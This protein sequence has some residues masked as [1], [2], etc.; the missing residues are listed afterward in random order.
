MKKASVFRIAFILLWLHSSTIFAEWTRVKTGCGNYLCGMQG[1]FTMND[2]YLFAGMNDGVYRSP[3]EGSTWTA[4]N[5]GLPE[6]SNTNGWMNKGITAFA[7]GGAN[8]FVG[9][10]DLGVFRSIDNGDNWSKINTGLGNLTVY[11]LYVKEPYLFSATYNGIYR[12]SDLDTWAPINNGLTSRW[13]YNFAAI[14]SRLFVATDGGGVFRS[15]DDG[16]TWSRANKGITDIPYCFAVSDL[17]LFCASLGGG[18]FRSNDS[19]DNW[20]P[21]NNGLT[22]LWIWGMAA[23]DQAVFVGTGDGGVFLTTDDGESW[24]NVGLTKDEVRQICIKGSNLFAGAAKGSIFMRPLTEMIPET[25]I[26]I[27]TNEL[28][29]DYR[30]QQNYPNPFNPS[31]T[32]EF[33]CP[34]QSY[35]S[36][37]IFDLL[38][39]KVTTLVDEECAPGHHT[40]V[41]SS[42]DETGQLA[43]AGIYIARFA[44]GDVQKSIKLTLIK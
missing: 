33:T 27:L 35:V 28:S 5:S 37:E 7:S 38:G 42:V 23:T 39:R 25:S 34:Q 29:A 21:V 36:L 41:W 22:S 15:D 24:T 9:C 17:N 8:L 16:D 43:P 31:T 40:E 4:A 10:L 3:D 6:G 30:L 2:V 1:G 14:G 18:V 12:S 19:G 13:A 11:G 20:S 44:A 32:I 26:S